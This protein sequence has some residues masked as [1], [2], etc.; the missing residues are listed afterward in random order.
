MKIFA[1]WNYFSKYDWLFFFIVPYVHIYIYISN[2]N[3][4]IFPT[5]WNAAGRW[6]IDVM[7]FF[8]FPTDASQYIFINGFKFIVSK[9]FVLSEWKPCTAQARE[10]GLIII[11]FERIF[12][13]GTNFFFFFVPGLLLGSLLPRMW[14]RRRESTRGHQ[15]ACTPQKKQQHCKP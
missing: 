6:F 12:Y 9:I 15:Q 4:N 8:Y 2:L 7:L 10:E 11:F 1:R 13:I 5:G 14:T 3:G